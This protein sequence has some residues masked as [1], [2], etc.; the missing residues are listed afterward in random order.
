MLYL[1][2]LGFKFIDTTG[3]MYCLTLKDNVYVANTISTLLLPTDITHL[4]SF[5]K[6]VEVLFK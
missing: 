6:A 4:E 5:K 1:F 2:S 3:Y